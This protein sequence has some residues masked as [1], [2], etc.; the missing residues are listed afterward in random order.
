[1]LH[2]LHIE[3]EKTSEELLNLLDL[4]HV[5]LLKSPPYLAHSSRYHRVSGSKL[6]VF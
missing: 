5:K 3:A 1:M 6:L 4:N 2:I